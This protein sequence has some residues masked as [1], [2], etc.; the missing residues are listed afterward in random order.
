[1]DPCQP[2]IGWQKR[3]ANSIEEHFFTNTV[4]PSLGDSERALA[5]SQCRSSGECPVRVSPHR[6]HQ[7]LRFAAVPS[8]APA[9][10]PPTP[11]FVSPQLPVWLSSLT[12]LAITGQLARTRG[13]WGAGG[14]L[15]SQRRARVCREAGARVRT[16]T[17]IRDMDLGMHD[18]LD[19][20]RLEV[21]A[22]GLPLH[23]G[24]QLAIDT[25]MV[26]PS[27]TGTESH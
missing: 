16:N 24:A 27:S 13:S 9:S 12:P 21:L 19:G 14:G 17:F 26:S 4:W 10:P 18:I 8:F 15:L 20:R 22:D 1:M 25:T 3:A 2:K 7:A 6:P 5:L 23:G 11:P